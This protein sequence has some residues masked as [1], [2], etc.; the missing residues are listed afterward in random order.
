M[1]LSD[2]DKKNIRNMK[3]FERHIKKH[4]TD[5]AICEKYKISKGELREIFNESNK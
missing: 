1:K 5:K 3:V 2:D 4:C